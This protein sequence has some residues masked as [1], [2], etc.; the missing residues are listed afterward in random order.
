MRG[1]KA[2]HRATVYVG[3]GGCDDGRAAHAPS[4]TD[5]RRMDRCTDGRTIR[6]GYMTGDYDALEIIAGLCTLLIRNGGWVVRGSFFA[7]YLY[8]ASQRMM[9]GYALLFCV[10][11]VDKKCMKCTHCESYLQQD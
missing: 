9:G 3:D 6:T 7:S 10:H 2:G 8:S 5:S 4:H 1:D 11:I